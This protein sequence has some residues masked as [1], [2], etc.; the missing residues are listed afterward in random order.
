MT[1]WLQA[2]QATKAQAKE[3]IGLYQGA[4]EVASE[5]IDKLQ[6]RIAA[7]SEDVEVVQARAEEATRVNKAAFQRAEALRTGEQPVENA[8]GGAVFETKARNRGNELQ[9]RASAKLA[10]IESLEQKLATEIQNHDAMRAK[11]EKEIAAWEGKSVAE[12]RSALKARDKAE[13]ARAAKP[14]AEEAGRARLTSADK[15]IDKTIR[16]IMKSDRD[17]S[18]DELRSRA[19][20]ITDRIIGSPDGRL[21]YDL[22]SGGPRQGAPSGEQ[23]RGPLAAR[24]FNIPDETIKD[25]LENDI[26]HIVAA[27]LRTMVPDVLLTEKFGDVDMTEAFRKINDD[28]AALSDA[29]KSDKERTRLEKQR[30]RAIDD[31]AAVR[32]RIRGIYG[33]SPEAPLRNVARAVGVMKNLNVLTSMGAAALTSLPDM[34][35][36]TFRHGLTNVFNDAWSPFF[37]YLAKQSDAWPEA[38]KQYRAMGIAVESVLA[39]RHHALTDTLD[40]YHPQSRVERTMQWATNKFQFINMLAPWTDF[41]KI[42]ASIV[43]GAEILRATEAAAAGKATIRQLRTLGESNIEPHMASRIHEAFAKGGEVR[44]G[45]HLPNTADWLDVEARRVFEGA[46]ARD[47]DIAVITP[48]QEKPLWMSHPILGVLGQFKSFTAAATERTMIANLQR[49]DAQVLQ[50]LIFSMGL[51]MLSYKLNSLTGGSPVSQ[52]PADWVKESISRGGLL[53]WFEEGNALASKA[54]RGGVDIYRLI[55]ADKPLSRFASRSAMDQLLGPTAGKIQNILSITSAGS[56]PSEWS[57]ADTKAIRRL[58]AG[59]NTF[60]LRRLFDEVEKSA[61]NTFGIEMKAK[62]ENR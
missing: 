57:E 39:S 6:A 45:V 51:G 27:H 18:R 37:Q 12:A 2:D 55:G 8:R 29:A 54:T 33:I 31:L 49:R 38:G 52:K 7:L 3:R 23:S 56:K 10:E 36:T 62:P 42:N 14:G 16:R 44:D 32:D 15:A 48:G 34:A 59:Q 41:A 5:Q 28:Y 13:A 46:V 19:Q 60:Y 40:N 35:G 21:P 17:L 61:N 22:G 53:G 11:I 43:A 9:D 24:E 47:V 58:I 26:E 25:F 4:L 30:Q 50:G 20:E 1:D